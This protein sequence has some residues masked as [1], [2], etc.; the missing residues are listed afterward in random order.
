MVPRGIMDNNRGLN[1]HIIFYSDEN[2]AG[3]LTPL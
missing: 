2:E 3:R 1:Y